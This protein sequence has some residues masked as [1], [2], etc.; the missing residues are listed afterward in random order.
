MRIRI[1]C[2]PRNIPGMIVPQILETKSRA[3][4]LCNAEFVGFPKIT[5]GDRSAFWILIP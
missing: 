3:A 1:E 2:M 5:L 4:N